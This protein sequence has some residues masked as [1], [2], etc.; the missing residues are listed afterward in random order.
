MVGR[1]VEGP[2]IFLDFETLALH[3]NDEAGDA[4]GAAVAPAGAREYEVVRRDVQAGVPDFCAVDAPSV[5]LAHGA[6]FHP[7]RVGAV[8]RLGQAEGDANRAV[9]D[10]RNERLLLLLGAEIAEHQHR[11]Q[12]TDD[13]A[14]VL[15]IVV[16]AQSLGRQMLPDDRH[17]EVGAVLAAVFLGQRKAIVSGPVGA[18]AHLGEQSLPFVARQAAALEVG[19]R[20][21]AAMVEEADVVVFA[22][23]RLDF[24]L[25][26]LVQF[27]KVRGDFGG[28]FE[29]QWRGSCGDIRERPA[30]LSKLRPQ[31]CY[32]SLGGRSVS[33]RVRKAAASQQTPG[34]PFDAAAA[35]E[36]APFLR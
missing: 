17:R 33:P 18:P 22:F 11:R 13:R 28:D 4:L 34:N 21:F 16:Q 23:E 19:A 29:I 31:P 27:G 15:Q 26:E 32:A 25:D 10:S 3:R 12:V 2:K 6:R 9:E 24:A 7:G 14:F 1:H 20:P 36:L 35:S 5:S 8:I 30:L